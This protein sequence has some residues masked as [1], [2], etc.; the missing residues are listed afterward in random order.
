M[1]K[2]LFAMLAVTV[3]LTACVKD[4]AAELTLGED[5][6][7]TASY[8]VTYAGEVIETVINANYP[9]T[10]AITGTC[11]VIVEP[12][13]GEGGETVKITVP[14]NLGEEKTEAQILFTCEGGGAKA[15][16]EVTIVQDVLKTVEYAGVTYKVKKLK[17]GNFWFVEKMKSI[18]VL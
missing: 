18:R 16:L 4:P 15:E 13:Q 12:Q 14:E 7:T 6:A 1:K 3:A 2:V 5:K 17:D 9:W 11:Q 8:D 10:A